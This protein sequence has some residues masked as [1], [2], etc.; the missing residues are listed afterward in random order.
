MRERSDSEAVTRTTPNATRNGGAERACEAMDEYP[1]LQSSVS[2]S[3]KGVGTYLLMIVGRNTG[4]EL[5]ATL[6]PRNMNYIVST[7]ML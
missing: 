1:I 7:S 6:Q 2:Y 4:I 5:N 3:Q